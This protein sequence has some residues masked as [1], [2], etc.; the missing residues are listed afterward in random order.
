MKIRICPLDDPSV[1]QDIKDRFIDAVEYRKNLKEAQWAINEKS[2][3]NRRSTMAASDLDTSEIGIRNRIMDQQAEMND[4]PD[5]VINHA[6]QNVR[7]LHAQ[8]SANPPVV[9]ARP[10]NTDL[11]SKRRAKAAGHVIEHGRKVYRIQ[12][13]VDLCNLSTILY[14]TGYMLTCWN[15]LDGK[16][17]GYDPKTGEVE[18]TG[19]IRIYSPDVWNVWLDPMAERA[20]D[21]RFIIEKQRIP[22][23][24]AKA[25]F[26][27]HWKQLLEQSNP[28]NGDSG[29][30]AEGMKD[31]N[32]RQEQYCFV[33]K[34]YE[35][36]LPVNAMQGRFCFLDKAGEVI[37][38]VD[39]N[40]YQFAEMINSV[41]EDDSEAIPQL[42]TAH[43]PLH[44]LTDV[45]V[46]NQVYGNSHLDWTIEAQDNMN[47]LDSMRM[48]NVRAAGIT[49]MIVPADSN[50]PEDRITDDAFEI[51]TTEGNQ[52]PSYINP[53]TLYGDVNVLRETLRGSIDELAGIN[54]AMKGVSERETSG[55][56]MTYA[57]NQANMVR[58]RLFNKYILFVQDLYSFYLNVCIKHWDIPQTIQVIGLENAYTTMDIQGQDI[59]S[60]YSISVDYGTNFS[61]DPTT[62]RQELLELK[63][64]LIEGGMTPQQFV[65]A[66]ALGDT[67]NSVDM[68][69]VCGTRQEEIFVR[70]IRENIYIAPLPKGDHAKYLAYANEYVDKAE[71]RDLTEQQQ[72]LIYKHIDEREKLVGSQAAPDPAQGAAP[73]NPMAAA[74]GGAPAGGPP[75][76][77]MG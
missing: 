68:M 60:G 35:K 16:V 57:T 52:Y 7:L 67:E 17:K 55:Y 75:M 22:L 58:R 71:F 14:G 29:T 21:I 27:K 40:P 12:E 61:L 59:S 50:I 65:E 8:M 18:M 34:Y 56:Q 69:Q 62:K 6:A 53:P 25:M 45:D 38:K 19:D 76:G 43:L 54:D 48:D 13:H 30:Y 24:L 2:V 37:G 44:I 10:A 26:P 39:V 49:R 32:R 31:I 11:Q 4:A 1:A 72:A 70:M 33:Y 51:I 73:A 9:N 5:V 42:P 63:E 3:Y 28:T 23:D 20:G 64:S 66:L 46:P 47:R 15:P 41:D 36:G 77:P 74:M